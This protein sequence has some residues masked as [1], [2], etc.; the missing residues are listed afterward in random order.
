[1]RVPRFLRPIWVR[2]RWNARTYLSRY[3][4]WLTA[5]VVAAGLDLASTMIFMLRDGVDAEA[6]PV[7]RLVAQYCGP[8]LGPILGK[9]CQLAALVLVTLYARPLA[10]PVFVAVTI[11]YGWAAWYNVWGAD[12]YVPRWMHYV[13]L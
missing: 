2:L 12:W 7:I 9:A 3:R 4:W 8:I 13:P 10:I 11:L 5:A 1:M 6:H